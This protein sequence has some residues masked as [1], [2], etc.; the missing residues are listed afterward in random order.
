MR[1][2]GDW[3]AFVHC[4]RRD[5]ARYAD[6]EGW[7]RET[8]FWVGATYRLGSWARTLPLLLRIPVL[9]LYRIVKLPWTLFLNVSIPAI[10]QI[11]PGLCLIHPRNVYIPGES[12]IG[13]NFLIFHEV[14]LGTGPVP[15]GSPRIGNSVDV[16]VGAKVLGGI[17]I[18]DGA[19]IGANCVVNRNVAPG[20][21][22]VVAANR[23]VPQAL[24]EAFGPDRPFAKGMPGTP[25]SE[26][27][28]PQEVEQAKSGGSG[29]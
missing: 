22:V 11:G 21:V 2:F 9:I 23:V 25:R 7:W 10:A 19:K 4:L 6:L 1:L 16:Y 3:R 14:T 18:G 15:P 29:G 20:S 24:V 5:A 13:E 17:T 8:G 27:P 26:D 28:E 12:E